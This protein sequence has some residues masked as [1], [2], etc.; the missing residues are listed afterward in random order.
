MEQIR[1]LIER[2]YASLR[3]SEK[4]VA[5]YVLGHTEK[6]GK[7]SLSELE[8]KVDVSQPTI[9]RFTKALGFDG[10]KEFKYALIAEKARQERDGREISAM[11]GYRISGKDQV[12]DVPAMAIATTIEMLENTLKCISPKVFSQIVEAISKARFIDIYGVENSETPVSDLAT[13]LLYLGLN[14]RMFHDYY[15]QRI[16]AGKLT[17]KDVAI[18]ISY[19]GCSKDTVDVMKIAKRRGA[20]TIVITNFADSMISKYADLT[21]CTSHDQ[22][23]YGDAIFSRTS[24]IAIVDMIYMGIL[25]SDYDAYAKQLDKSSRIIQDKAYDEKH[26]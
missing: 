14:C 11:H 8:R 3:R 7:L 6:V 13:K 21:L 5:D 19:S 2:N 20:K 12:K 10:Y 26:S 23:L 22:Y 17:P 25:L 16:C 4:K 18:G 1:F 15:L 24:Q 9:I